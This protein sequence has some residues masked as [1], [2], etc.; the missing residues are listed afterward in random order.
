LVGAESPVV[1]HLVG[2]RRS[3]EPAPAGV[4]TQGAALVVIGQE[5]SVRE[6][7]AGLEK[8]AA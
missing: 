2:S 4:E 3:V 7:Q 8:C 1:V 5:L 6:L